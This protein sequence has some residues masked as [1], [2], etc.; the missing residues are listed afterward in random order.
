VTYSAD[1]A[2][3]NPKSSL[4]QAGAAGDQARGQKKARTN[5]DISEN[6]LDSG[7]KDARRKRWVVKND[8]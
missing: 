4:A 7:G 8:N 6:A 2:A 1:A 3:I 5:Q